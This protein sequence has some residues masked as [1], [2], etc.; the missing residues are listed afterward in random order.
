LLDQLYTVTFDIINAP[1]SAE[2][3]IKTLI[4]DAAAWL[5][6][7]LTQDSFVLSQEG[8]HMLES[9]Y[10]RF[11]VVFSQDSNSPLVVHLRSLGGDAQ[12]YLAR[13]ASDRSTR[14]LLEAI[15]RLRVSLKDFL[16]STLSGF[17]AGARR[18]RGALKRDLFLWVLPRM[19]S[20]V[21]SFPLPRVEYKDSELELVLDTLTIAPFSFTTSLLPDHI[22]FSN[23]NE[24]HVDNTRTNTGSSSANMR[25]VQRAHLRLEGIRFSVE[26]L[27]YLVRY[28]PSGLLG[29]NYLDRGL[30]SVFVGGSEAGRGLQLDIS[31]V[32]RTDDDESTR[33]F[34]VES[35]Q[36]DI[37]GLQFSL[38]HTRHWLLNALVT[39]N[40]A[41]P[42]VRLVVAHLVKEQLKEKLELLSTVLGHLKLLLA[43]E[44]VN[45]ESISWMQC[46]RTLIRLP[47]VISSLNDE[48][49][50]EAD[51]EMQEVVQT[52]ETTITTTGVVQ[53][54]IV[55][56]ST[57][58]LQ[59][60]EPVE[61]SVLA[62]GLGP[63]VIPDVAGPLTDDAVD[64]S[65]GFGAR[66]RV[67]VVDTAKTAEEQ[68]RR[69]GR[70]LVHEVSNA[71]GIRK[72]LGQGLSNA[73]SRESY[74]RKRAGW[75]SDAFTL[76][77]DGS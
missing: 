69:T 55:E 40:I 9:L 33:M 20:A 43:E 73:T 35:V 19:L 14:G 56:R 72:D 49:R 48:E 70:Q 25:T 4:S 23:W 21:K 26:Q 13:V 36:A 74:E 8:S 24:L 37:P 38:E 62:I 41:G 31:I 46:Y 64:A 53:E 61:G 22:H 50:D 32:T 30:L 34:E 7:S 12:A 52:T 3:G 45:G 6:L 44:A 65:A 15:D 17:A 75:R 54:T 11:R 58:I 77:V 51:D 76:S 29:F 39:K 67:A 59:G 71:D 10:T 68:L 2:T 63:Q 47:E 66:A 27:G 1:A 5:Q 60:E 18:R 57:S 42:T 28:T 16:P